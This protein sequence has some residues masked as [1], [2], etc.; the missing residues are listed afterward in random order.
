MKRDRNAK[1]IATLGPSSSSPKIIRQLFEAG[2]DV[3]RL[4]F[5]HGTH[6]DHRHR[7]STIRQI[8]EEYGRPV[9]VLLDL[10]G[11]KLRLGTFAEGSAQLVA[12]EQ[13]RLDLDEIPGDARRA[14]LPHAEVFRAVSKGAELLLDDGKIRLRVEDVG[15]GFAETAVLVGGRV[16]DRKGVNVPDAKLPISSLTRK[17]REDLA[18]GLSL[19]VDWVALSFVQSADDIDEARALI[20]DRAWIMA[21]LEKPLAI[22]HLQRI[23]QRA[24]GVMVAR[25]DLGVELPAEQI[26]ELQ[27]RIV[28]ECRRVGK[29]V[30]VATQMLESMTNSPVPTR[31]ETS[32]VACAI[33]EGAD[34]VMLSAESASGKFPIEAVSTMNRIIERVE[35]DPAYREQI[36]TSHTRAESTVADAI[37]CA[38]RKAVQLIDPAVTVT[39]TT[40]GFTSLRAARERIAT[41]IIALT[42][43][44][45]VAR[46][47]ALAWGIH[48]VPFIEASD[49][50]DVIGAACRIAVREGFGR[51]GDLVAIAAGVPFGEPGTTNL[52][53]I[54]RVATPEHAS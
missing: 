17:D 21:K 14:P 45:T 46:R 6:E 26:P 2:V 51:D 11:P 48:A 28:R 10:Q 52:L 34:A 15:D 24:D 41:S 38:L 50:D 12:G 3:F 39:Y 33:Y 22:D 29:V 31:A 37:C 9:G 4:N 5:S 18:F 32:D 43:S 40:S 27:R 42:P 16:S 8:E 54:A 20:G 1:I 13:F 25:G 35:R 49:M 30:V 53:Q 19:G 44:E 36:D 7:I 47:L 23:V